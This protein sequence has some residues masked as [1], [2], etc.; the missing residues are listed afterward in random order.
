M[1]EKSPAGLVIGAQCDPDRLDCQ[2]GGGAVLCLSFSYH[3]IFSCPDTA[4]Y[5][6]DSVTHSVTILILE[7]TE[8]SWTLVTFETFDRSEKTM[9]DQQK[10]KYI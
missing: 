2:Q 4:Q 9:S 7:H 8:T 5:A 1:E 3:H 6:R 10:D